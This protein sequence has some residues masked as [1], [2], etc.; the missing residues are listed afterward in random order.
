[1][2]YQKHYNLLVKKAQERILEGY[3]EK[4]HILPK[5]LGGGDE[6]SNLVAL[7]PEEHF[8][9]HQLLVKI[10]PN[11]PK[12]LFAVHM[13][14]NGND[15]IRRNNKMYGWLRKKCNEALSINKRNPRKKETKP[16]KKRV[17]SEEHKLKI[18]LAG[19]GKTRNEETKLRI[20]AAHKNKI[21]SE[22]TKQ[23]M[24]KPK[25]NRGPII[26]ETFDW[27]CI[28]CGTIIQKR[29]LAKNRNQ[30]YCSSS[31]FYGYKP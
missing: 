17:L 3:V 9:A 26:I 8:V 23:K 19:K 18:G 10:Y 30:R 5:C 14:C 6:L 15:K 13:M 7:T 28:G 29:N 24:R 25:S 11:E 1:M 4:H 31:C 21:L 22:A 20:G 12:L 2:D 27:K 16:R